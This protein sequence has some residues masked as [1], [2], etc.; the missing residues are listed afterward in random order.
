MGGIEIVLRDKEGN[1]K[2]AMKKERKTIPGVGAVVEEFGH[3][4][5]ISG[6]EAK[7]VK[8]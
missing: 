8:K 7:W 1:V 3:D 5:K 4:P 6:K 2:E